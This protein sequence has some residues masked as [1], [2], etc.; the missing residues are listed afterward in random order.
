MHWTRGHKVALERGSPV[1]K[2]VFVLK[3][4]ASIVAQ[5]FMVS[6]ARQQ[7]HGIVYQPSLAVF[8]RRVLR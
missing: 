2:P 4:A 3:R 1:S 6:L 7:A 5:P 8:V